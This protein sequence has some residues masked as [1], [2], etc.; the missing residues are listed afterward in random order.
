MKTYR[1]ARDILN[2]VEGELRH[3]HRTAGALPLERAAALL[4][5]GRHYEVVEIRLAPSVPTISGGYQV[6][7]RI[8]TRVL[9]VITVASGCARALSIEDRVLLERVAARLARFLTSNGRYILRHAR[10]AAAGDDGT[11]SARSARSAS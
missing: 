11:P 3:P 2:A 5:D 8:G 6:P 9:G 7:I 4:C 1:S 10:E